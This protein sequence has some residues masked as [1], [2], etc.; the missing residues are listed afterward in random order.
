MR[1][2]L[3]PRKTL[4]VPGN[5]ARARQADWQRRGAPHIAILLVAQENRL[6][7]RI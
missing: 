1:N 7:W 6:A 4:A 3:E 5:V 2:M